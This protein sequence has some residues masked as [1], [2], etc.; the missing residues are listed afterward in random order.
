M[1]VIVTIY[2]VGLDVTAKMVGMETCVKMTSMN[3]F[4]SH[5][6]MMVIALTHLVD[7]YVIAK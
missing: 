7:S 1:V 5:A 2:M 3:V 6:K 4:L